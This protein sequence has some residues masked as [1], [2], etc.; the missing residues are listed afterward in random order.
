MTEPADTVTE[1][2]LAARLRAI[3]PD[4]TR[5]E[6]AIAQWLM[7]NEATLGLET[8]ASIAAKT[9]VSPITVSRFLRRLGYK[10]MAALKEDLQAAAVNFHLNAVDR[11]V[12]LDDG[13][14]GTLLKR[15]AEAILALSSQ[16][17]RPEWTEAIA[18]ID[19]AEDVS[20]TGFQTVRGLAED[21]ARRLSIVR[22]SVDFISA[23]DTGLAEWLPTGGRRGEGRCLVLVD[24]VPY[25]R[26][27]EVIVRLA[28]RQGATV[29]VVTDE[30][31][32]WAAAHT[33]YVFFAATRVGA[34]LE[35]TG[36]LTTLL[37]LIIH[38]VAECNPERAKR[39]LAEW[40]PILRDLDLF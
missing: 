31:N 13:E 37:N 30:L 39:R 5:S 9:G 14:L 23:H 8:G 34:F 3:L 7:L 26:E 38:A 1:S 16:F 35:S 17:A 28:R 40:P 11:Y 4:L 21:F 25:A 2:A 6:A 19:A 24:A 29:V 22:G 36:P 12:R 10:G 32:T 27:A 33:P 20:V 18:A 15:D